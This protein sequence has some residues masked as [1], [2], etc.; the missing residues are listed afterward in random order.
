MK[1]NQK[2][3]S[4]DLFS[5]FVNWFTSIGEEKAPIERE[6]GGKDFFSKLMNKIS[7]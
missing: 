7:D 2:K 1:S 6:G 3:N 4:Q 5:T